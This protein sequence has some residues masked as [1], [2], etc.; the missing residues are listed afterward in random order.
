MRTAQLIRDLEGG[1]NE[2]ARQIAEVI[3]RVR[4]EICSSMSSI[5]TR[6]AGRPQSFHQGVSGG[7]AEWLR[8]N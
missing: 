2:Q 1:K 5:T 4:P 7:R 8:A 3:Q 6:R